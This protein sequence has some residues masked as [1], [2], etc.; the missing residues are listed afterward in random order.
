MFR[1]LASGCLVRK[2]EF[3]WGGPRKVKNINTCM[4][5][6]GVRVESKQGQKKKKERVL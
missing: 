6:V 4:S 3:F 1:P 2:P 5:S